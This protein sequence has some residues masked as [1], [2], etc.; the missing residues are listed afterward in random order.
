MFKIL[1]AAIVCYLLL[2][3]TA[4]NNNATNIASTDT[5]TQ[6]NALGAFS[7]DSL[8]KHI[9][10]LSGDD[11]MGRKP[12]TAGETKT[13]NYLQEQ[14]KWAG[15][16]PGNGDSYL[17][18]VPMVKITTTAAPTMQVQSAKGNFNLM[19]LDD[20]VIWTDKT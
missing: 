16:E 2:S 13:I 11:F 8:G 10:A 17:Q 15:L 3:L 19:G 6:T 9:A 18:E 20:Y 5:S 1:R 14:F 12:F 4:C 7:A